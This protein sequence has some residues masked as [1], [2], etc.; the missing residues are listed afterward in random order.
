[1][2]V[3]F[4]LLLASGVFAV[5]LY[6]RRSGMRVEIR[7]GL[8][9]GWLAGLF[10]FVLF[11]VLLAISVALL[12]ALLRDGSL[13]AMYRQQ[14][15]A[16]GVSEDRIQQAMEML[17]SPVQMLSLLA[18]LFVFST[19]TPAAGGAIGARLLGKS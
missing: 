17:R 3:R 7:G 9:M 18:Y 1:M 14:M 11:A 10:C 15:A 12:A 2:W 5:H 6:Q 8:K 16:M 13:A 19:F 4:L